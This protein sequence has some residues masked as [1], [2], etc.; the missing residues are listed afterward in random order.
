MAAT[1]AGLGTTYTNAAAE[2][3]TTLVTD[4][5][6]D[7]LNDARNNAAPILGLIPSSSRMVAGK[8]IVENVMF[9][10]NG[11]AFTFVNKG[12]RLPDPRTTK[13][14]PYAYKTRTLFARMILDGSLL[15]ATN[16]DDVRFI[17]VVERDFKAISDDMAVDFGRMLYGDGS[18]RLAEIQAVPGGAGVLTLRLNSNLESVATCSTSPSQHLYVGMRFAIVSPAG[19]VRGT[20]EIVSLDSESLGPPAFS[21]IT[22]GALVPGGTVVASALPAGTTA[23]DWL[24]K[25]SV[26]DQ[27]DGVSSYLNTAFRG[28][29]M[30]LAGIMSDDGVLDGNGVATLPAGASS[31]VGTDDYTG[32]V[33]ANFQGLPVAGNS[34]NRAIV[35]T[36]GGVLR[37]VTEG[38]LQLASSRIEKQNNGMV[39]M[40]VSNYGVRD[41]YGISLLSQKQYHNTTELRGGWSVLDWNGK[42]WYVDRL[43]QENR[44]YMLG[45]T[46]GGFTQ[47][48]NTPFQPL[49]P[50]GPHWYRLQDQD[51][52]QAAW[53]ADL[54]IGVGIR[55]RC[56]GL[57]TDLNSAVA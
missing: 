17:G 7:R 26:T 27:A 29:P 14:L 10:R 5:Y 23:G 22:T 20:R 53:V 51:L 38:L 46:G 28:E 36:G 34:F 40:M 8:Y 48:V 3:L 21:Q 44:I 11:E 1:T 52:Y 25:M 2:F 50:Y 41:S 13:A 56:G 43:C 31:Y 45:L 9:G 18:G 12:G 42:P 32:T 57:I 6:S 33:P 55:E 4:D 49:D 24:V 35:M 30:G 16:K 54:N 19:V 47:H 15:R 37:P 39:D